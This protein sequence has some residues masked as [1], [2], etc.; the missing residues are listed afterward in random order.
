M[1][2]PGAQLHQ[3]QLPSEAQRQEVETV[4][5]MQVRTAAADQ[6]TKLLAGKAPAMDR[7]LKTAGCIE[8]YIL[9][10]A[11]DPVPV[12]AAGRPPVS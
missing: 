11:P 8:R 1:V 9:G 3:V 4:R 6:A 7:W 10:L 12:S 2:P 5:A